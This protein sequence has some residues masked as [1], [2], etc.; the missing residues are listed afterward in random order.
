VNLLFPDPIYTVNISPPTDG[1]A[2][3]QDN[4]GYCIFT[5]GTSFS[6]PAVSGVVALMKSADRDRRFDRY[7]YLQIL[8]STSSYDAL[9]LRG[10]ETE[11]K[12]N[13]GAGLVNA[14]KAVESS[15]KLK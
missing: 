8:Q 3:F 7:Q 15:E 2:P 5:Q 4:R 14:L 13:F 11:N 10:D 6:A 1:F 12:F 9:K